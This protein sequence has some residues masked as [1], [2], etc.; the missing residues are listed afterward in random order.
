MKLL[1]RTAIFHD[2]YLQELSSKL[3]YKKSCPEKFCNIHM[4]TPVL[5]SLFNKVGGLCSFIKKGLQR[6]CFPANIANFLRTAILKNVCERLLLNLTD[7]SEQLVFREATF[8]E[9]L[10]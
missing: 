2:S 5:E 9:Q 1:F 3:F 8:S 7:F 6:R 10:I 4:K